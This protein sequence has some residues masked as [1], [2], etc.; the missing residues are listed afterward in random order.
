MYV[1]IIDDML[2]TKEM[3]WMNIKN[4]YL[5]AENLEVWLQ[6]LVKFYHILNP[7]KSQRMFYQIVLKWHQLALLKYTRRKKRKHVDILLPDIK[8][9]LWYKHNWK[10]N[11]YTN[12]IFRQLRLLNYMLF[13][14]HKFVVPRIVLPCW[15]WP[16]SCE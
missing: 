11:I 2:G 9:G 15:P 5:P 14:R 7:D 10:N 12:L 6:V 16:F 1:S 3:K 8:S 4:Y 13:H